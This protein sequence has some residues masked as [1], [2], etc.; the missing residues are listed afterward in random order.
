MY[1][2]VVVNK[3]EM[4]FREYDIYRS[5]YCGLCDVLGEK[6]GAGG[7][8]SISY[9]MT[10]LVMLLTGLYEPAIIFERKRCIAHPVHKHDIRKSDITEYVAD[11][12]VLMTYYKCLDDWKD[13]RKI[14]RKVFA[15]GLKSKLDDIQKRYPDKAEAI[16]LYMKELSELEN[17][18]ETNIDKVSAC[19]ANIMSQLIV[20]KSDEWQDILK[21][22]GFYLGKYIYILDAYE[23]LK[24]DIKNGRYNMLKA[25]MQESDFD[26]LIEGI[27]NS[28]MAQ[29]AR[30]FEQLP[31]I[32]DVEI[33]R[34]IIY[35]GVWTRFEI[36]RERNS[37]KKEKIN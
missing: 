37:R 15:S 34:N 29:C 5:Y 10:F 28:L 13:E 35:S 6:F 30:Y 19:F 18:G 1:G 2:Y 27:L 16:R 17:V 23:D 25:H 4:K 14:T 9:D 26:V 33:L 7:K 3:P 20:M 21:N 8:L 22:I 31:I 11:M 32:Q 12:N 36:A 24:E